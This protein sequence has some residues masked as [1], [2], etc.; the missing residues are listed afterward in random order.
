MRLDQYLVEQC[1]IFSRNKAQELIKAG[2]VTVGTKVIKKPSFQVA[3]EA[4]SVEEGD[5]YVSRAAWKLRGFLSETELDVSGLE[6]LDIG[7][8]TGGFTQVLLENGV[9]HVYAVDVGSDQLHPTLQSDERV[10]SIENTDIRDY[11]PER[12]FELVVSDVSFISLM[13]ILE[14]VDEL[15]ER[16]I[17]LLFKPQFEVGREAKRDK[18]GVVTDLKAIDKAM[19]RF[20]D[21]ATLQGWSLRL[22]SPSVLSGKEGNIEYCYYFEKH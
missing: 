19:I 22:K 5:H 1:G 13:H 14:R 10:T 18:K 15:A 11:D 8:S 12:R 21:A 2:K 6:A 7:S 16:H 9:S 4:V 3:D 20:E 17:I